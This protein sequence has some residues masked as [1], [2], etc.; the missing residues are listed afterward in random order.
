MLLYVLLGGLILLLLTIGLLFLRR[1]PDTEVEGHSP[2]HWLGLGIALGL[3]IG[4]GAGIVLGI[5]V[6]NPTLGIIIGPGLG[7]GIGAAIGAG[8][9][10]RNRD[11]I[12]PLTD[13]ERRAQRWILLF[14]SLILVIGVILFFLILLEGL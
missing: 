2:G 5:A 11:R 6:G 1:P 3:P 10:A 8:L 7:L 4:M 9:E 14:G 13:E 12:Q